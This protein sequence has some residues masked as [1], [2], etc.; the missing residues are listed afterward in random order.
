MMRF[1]P[2]ALALLA[3]GFSLFGASAALA[4]PP[5]WHVPGPHGTIT[6]FGSVHLLSKDTA[7][8]TPALDA[9]IA[10]ADQVW[11]EIP[12][13]EASQKNASG[14]IIAKGRAMPGQPLS[15]LLTG[16][17]RARLAR[18]EAREGL[19]PA[20]IEGLK[21]W[22]AELLISVNWYKLKGAD[23]TL[24]VEQEISSAL[25][26]AK[27]RAA[28]ETVEEQIRF[29][30]DAST[31][32]QVESLSQTLHDIE[33]DPG[34]FDRLAAAWATGDEKALVREAILPM[35][36][37]APAAYR[38]LIIERNRR[39]AERILQLRASGGRIFMVVG[40]G[41]LVGPDGVPALLRA[42]GIKVEG[43]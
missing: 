13:D 22:L 30:A 33:D 43:P 27:P 15:N 28:L 29:F 1:P 8:R 37:D 4:V 11:F 7:W 17:D 24:G 26:P 6:L 39:W 10:R 3:L 31:A 36:R 21:P 9:E 2:F 38:T 35:K 23:P 40:A 12:F 18:V 41:H 34:S 16:K 19:P 20:A 5:V 25:P 14:L 42:R 32:A